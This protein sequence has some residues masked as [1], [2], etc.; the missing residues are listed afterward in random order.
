MVIRKKEVNVFFGQTS[1][2]DPSH[3]LPQ[4]ERKTVESET[5]FFSAKNKSKT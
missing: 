3:I 4:I 5:C 2:R 1:E